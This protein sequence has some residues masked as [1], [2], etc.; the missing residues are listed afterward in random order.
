MSWAAAPW[1]GPRAKTE[2]ILVISA[3]LCYGRLERYR[4][5]VI[6]EFL[7]A[8]GLRI[9]EAASLTPDNIDTLS[10]T[11][12]VAEGKGRTSRLAF[13]TG[14]AAEV[15]AHYL[16]RG[17]KAVLGG[18]NGKHGHTLFGTCPE[19]L[20]VVVN[21]GLLKTCTLLDLPVITSHG[22]RHSLGTHLLHAGCD[23][24]YIQVILGH[25][26]LRT[27]QVYTRVDK[28]ELRESLDK[29]HPRRRH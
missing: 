9:S 25:E 17:R 12:Y 28:E 29:Y 24:R 13:M 22:F 26:R 3:Q 10:R 20:M 16:N 23:M 11:V 4:L 21:K 5:Q 15:M 6:G 19:R 8:T 14:F 18:G 1:T 27:T 7:Y 2:R